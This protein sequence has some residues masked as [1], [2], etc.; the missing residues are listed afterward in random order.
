M[1]ATI[2]GL[3]LV[4]LL[5]GDPPKSPLERLGLLDAHELPEASGIVKSRRFPDIFWIHN[6]SG[7]APRLYAVRSDGTIVRRYKIEIPNVDW[8]DIAMDDEG[9]LYIGDIGNNAGR[10]PIRAI[11]QLA[12][13]DP[14]KPAES[15][16]K[17]LKAWFYR[18]DHD[19]RF[20]AESL[21]IDRGQALLVAKTFDSRNA[22]LYSLPLDK[23]ASFFKP[24][25]PR[26]IGRL[27]RFN[28]PATGADLS[29][30][31]EWLAVCS[32]TKTLVY[33]RTSPN[34]Q[35]RP[36]PSNQIWKLEAEVEYPGWA[37]EAICWDARDLV[38]AGED[39]RICRLTE[40]TW[41]SRSGSGAK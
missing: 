32:S 17:A 36:E 16:V 29:A 26:K 8:E 12:E 21:C 4:L 19:D 27:D 41:R 14:A 40:S 23:P 15:P 39:R 37:V 30:D 10:L 24:A 34:L 33:Q 13:P 5:E 6:D 20:D 7:N 38:L 18:F 35:G 28:V 3:L 11:Y 1:L 22:E 9:H 31:G 2:A 25:I